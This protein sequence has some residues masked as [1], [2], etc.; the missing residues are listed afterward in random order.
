[1]PICKHELLSVSEPRSRGSRRDRVLFLDSAVG[2]GRGVLHAFAR[3]TY[4]SLHRFQSRIRLHGLVAGVLEVRFL[5]P[6]PAMEYLPRAALRDPCR[7]GANGEDAVTG[8]D[9]LLLAR[10]VARAG[11]AKQ[12]WKVSGQEWF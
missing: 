5:W 10:A 11:G 7:F 4:A 9:V 6:S 1:M 12:H 3:R 2:D 8:V